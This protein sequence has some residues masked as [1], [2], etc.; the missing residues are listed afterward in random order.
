MKKVA[1][2]Q[3][4]YIPW[5]GYFDLIAA[6]DEFILYDDVQFTSRDW[7][8]RNMIK[9]PTGSQWISVPV[10]QSIHRRIRDVVLLN[11]KWQK[12]HWRSIEINYCFVSAPSGNC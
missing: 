3:S 4:S 12:K 2:V 6:V 1:I 8:N 7:R 5:R 10:G 9:T 11:Q